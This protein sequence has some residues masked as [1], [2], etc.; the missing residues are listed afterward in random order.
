MGHLLDA[1]A[2][3]ANA[4]ELHRSAPVGIEP[5]PFP[6]RCVIRSVIMTATVGEACLF[7]AGGS[8]SVDVHVAI[9]CGRVGQRLAVGRPAVPPR[10][11][12]FRNPPRHAAIDGQRVDAGLPGF[13]LVADDERGAVGRDAVVVVAGRGK[14]GVDALR[15]RAACKIDPPDQAVAVENEK[16]PVARPVWRLYQ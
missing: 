8:D 3:G 12:V 15:F 6:V 13:G 1:A 10:G 11:Y 7:T 2:V 4:P 9:A 16:Y 5:Y 14:A